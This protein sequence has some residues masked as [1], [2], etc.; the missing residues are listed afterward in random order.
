MLVNALLWGFATA[1]I[2][3]NVPIKLFALLPH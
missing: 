1:L 2:V 3:L